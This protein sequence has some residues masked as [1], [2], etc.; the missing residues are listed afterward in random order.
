MDVLAVGAEQC[1]THAVFVAIKRILASE[2][3][4][5]SGTIASEASGAADVAEGACGINKI[6]CIY[7][8]EAVVAG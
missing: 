3:L 7:A 6:G 4:F 5:V 2:A 8:L 1:Y